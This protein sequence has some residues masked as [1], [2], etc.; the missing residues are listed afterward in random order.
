MSRDGGDT[1]AFGEET[2]FAM[3]DDLRYPA[4]SI[5]DDRHAVQLCFDERR[6]Q[7]IGGVRKV[8]E[9]TCSSVKRHDVGLVAVPR[10][11]VGNA[12]LSAERAKFAFISGIAEGRRAY[13]VEGRF[14]YS[15]TK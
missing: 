10:D 1:R 3:S 14:G 13:D 8:E 2:E 15:P 12:E 7:G 11:D 9:D 6:W 5:R 4:R